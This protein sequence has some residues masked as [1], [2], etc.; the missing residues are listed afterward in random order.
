M[1]SVTPR[2]AEDGHRMH[3]I[4]PTVVCL[5]G[6]VGL[7]SST[8]AASKIK[9]D[10]QPISREDLALKDNPAFHGDDA[11][12]LYR[13]VVID[14]WNLSM[15]EYIRVK[16]FTEEGRKWADVQVP[17]VPGFWE[18]KELRA[19]TIHPDGT[20]TDFKGQTFDAL[21]VKARGVKVRL[22]R[23]SL[24]DVQPG[25][26]IEYI[27]EHHGPPAFLQN[28]WTIQTDLYT[29]RSIFT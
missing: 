19:R 5:F 18:I 1:A 26:I 13:E 7:A 3:F 28:D 24:P 25:C 8:R 17:F 4:R 16:I 21:V 20:I 23:F 9:V 14:D 10:W 11:M 15:T 22:R 29:R 6:L 27:Y 12:I 2:G